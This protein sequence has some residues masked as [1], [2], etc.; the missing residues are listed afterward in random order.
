MLDWRDLPPANIRPYPHSD[1]FF[2]MAHAV[3]KQAG[4]DVHYVS[5]YLLQN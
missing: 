2:K 4:Y 1:K 3:A 5:L